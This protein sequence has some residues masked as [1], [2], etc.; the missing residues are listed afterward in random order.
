MI[1]VEGILF[2]KGKKLFL[3][4][5]IDFYTDKVNVLIHA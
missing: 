5:C 3:R 4:R 1:I 2:F